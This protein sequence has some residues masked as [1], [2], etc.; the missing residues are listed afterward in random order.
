MTVA[1]G[2]E[3]QPLILSINTVHHSGARGWFRL[4]ACVK[5]DGYFLFEDPIPGSGYFT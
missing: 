1:S 4:P 5:S 2:P 3:G